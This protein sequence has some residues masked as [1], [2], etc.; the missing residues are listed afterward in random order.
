MSSVLTC[1]LQLD[2]PNNIAGKKKAGGASNGAE[3]ADGDS[4]TTPLLAAEVRWPWGPHMGRVHMQQALHKRG[5]ICHMT[6]QPR[7]R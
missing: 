3:A 6:H 1:P 7:G 4:V 5:C 2:L